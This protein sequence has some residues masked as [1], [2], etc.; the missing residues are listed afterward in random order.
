MIAVR[1]LRIFVIT[2]LLK[3]IGFTESRIIE[4]FEN[5]SWTMNTFDEWTA[6]WLH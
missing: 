1:R 5:D 4:A 3:D 6:G 2:L